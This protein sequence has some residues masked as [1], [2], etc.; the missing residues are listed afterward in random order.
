MAVQIPR[1]QEMTWLFE[2]G[3]IAVHYIFCN[4]SIIHSST[5]STTSST[6]AST[7]STTFAS[8]DGAATAGAAILNCASLLIPFDVEA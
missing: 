6:A 2:H 8:A 1:P 5:A 7:E 4:Q 3:T